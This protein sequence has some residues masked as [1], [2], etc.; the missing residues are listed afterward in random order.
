MVASI[1][2]LSHDDAAGLFLLVREDLTCCG[3][4]ESLTELSVLATIWLGDVCCACNSAKHAAV[5]MQQSCSFIF[6]AFL[7]RSTVE[8][9]LPLLLLYIASSLVVVAV[10]IAVP[11][12]CS[13]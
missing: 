4:Q 1:S 12:N 5:A 10:A 3:E 2:V 7:S 6:M 11:R 8:A 9:P 13:S